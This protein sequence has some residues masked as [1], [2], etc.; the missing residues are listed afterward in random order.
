M[1]WSMCEHKFF[2]KLHIVVNYLSGSFGS[3]VSLLRAHR[4]AHCHLLDLNHFHLA[5]LG[6]ID[7]EEVVLRGL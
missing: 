1:V 5:R 2:V 6:I 3:G 7:A 4:P